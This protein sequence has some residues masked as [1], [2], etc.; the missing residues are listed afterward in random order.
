M[1]SFSL[2][3]TVGIYGEQRDAIQAMLDYDYL[4][5]K[6]ETAVQCI[7]NPSLT[8]AQGKSIYFYGSKEV[9]LSVFRSIEEAMRFT[10]VT[11][12]INF[13]SARSAF[14]VTEAALG[15]PSIEKIVVIAE[16]M[17]E[18]EA[19]LLRVQAAEQGK[20]VIGPA[21]VGGLISGVVKIGYAGG[22]IQNIVANRLYVR[23]NVGILSKSGGMLNEFMT[24]VNRA[25][26]G[27]AEAIAIGGD[28][29]PLTT[30]I[31]QIERFEAN[32]DIKL[33]LLQGEVG[34]TQEYAIAHLLEE[35]KISKPVVVWIS[36]T[37][38]EAL[39]ENIQFGHAGAM[40]NSYDE[41]AKAKLAALK[42]AGAQVPENYA[43]LEALLG[44][45][46]EKVGVT[47]STED[48]IAPV[49]PQDFSQLLKRG[50]LRYPKQIVTSISKKQ[51]ADETYVGRPIAEIAAKQGLGYI[52]GLLWFKQEF[53][54]PVCALFELILK[55]TADHGP[56][57]SGAHNTI[58]TARA[59]KNL[60]DSLIA[61]LLPIGPRFGGAV[62]DAAH[63]F[64]W[65]KEQTLSA[66][67]FVQEM[68]NKGILIPGI[69][70]KVKSKTNP[71][72]RVELLIAEARKVAKE[73]PY[74][75]YALKVEEVTTR[76][77]DSLI[78]N[79]DGAMAVIL[80]D[81][82]SAYLSKEELERL[83]EM[84]AFNAFFVLG[85]SIGLIGHF[86]DQKRLDQPLYR[87]PEWDILE[88][89]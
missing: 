27:V 49:I 42:K 1:N 8:S 70:H 59:G 22:T 57:V 5:G 31:E 18:R 12:L 60:V 89:D 16:G 50:E 66:Y 36:G 87:H 14:A 80:L 39:T 75:E 40:A 23:G 67:A 84:E 44:E 68:K 6:K 29:Y 26:N 72:K 19:R 15:Q 81:V 41:T 78:L 54:E 52:M 32:P 76:K 64:K 33:I 24:M 37:G 73:L 88:V 62:N 83:I 56:S 2:H 38:A 69:G 13:A 45:I 25:S 46:A 77:K 7:I 4:C 79:V 86:I 74:L 34:G 71:D 48:G 35:G 61:G 63:Y 3:D 9:G 51:G 55:L 20:I 11:I 17:P 65:G 47:H 10:P 82:L 21:T 85:R 30:L 43:G 58:V 28:R 53:P